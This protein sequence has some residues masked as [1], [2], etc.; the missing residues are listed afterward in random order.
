M[1]KIVALILAA[2]LVLSFAGCSGEQ[3]KTETSSPIALKAGDVELT[4]EDMNYMY[5][6]TF[7]DIYNTFYNYYGEYL[8]YIL[9]I[10]KPLEEQMLD[11]NLSWHQYVL[12]V[13]LDSTK[14]IIG[15]YKA[16][17]EN[18]F[19]LPE[20]YQNDIDTFDEQLTAI[21]EEYGMTKEEYLYYSYGEDV[22]AESVKNMTEIQLYCNA[23][24]ENYSANLEISDEDIETYY[25]ANK[26]A[27]DT[28]DFHFYTTYYGEEEALTQEEA[29]A[30]ANAIA[31][32]TTVE[33][34][35]ALAKDFT[36]DEADKQYF[37]ESDPT[38]YA[39][40]GYDA[41]G[42]EE[43]SEWLFDESRVT[44][45]TM[46]YH[47]EDYTGYIAIMFETRV[48]PDYDYIN[49]R[50][51]LIAPEKNAEGTVGDA[52]WAAAEAKANEIY[53]G[54][55]AG[56][57][58]EETF[59][60]LAKEYSADGNAAQGG[61]YENVYKG[62]MVPAFNDWCFD[63]A[64]TVGDSGIVKTPYGYHLMYFAGFGENNLTATVEPLVE[65][66][67]LSAFLAECEINSPAE[68]T[69]EINNVGGMLDD[70]VNSANEAAGTQDSET[71]KETKSFTGIIIGALVA[72]ILVC[73][74][75]IIKN[76][77]KKKS[78]TEVTEENEESE[79]AEESALEATEEDL[80]E[81][82]LAAEEAFEETASEETEEV[83]E[84]ESSEE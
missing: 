47:D 10:T 62:Q 12:D 3:S 63:E 76:G 16:A 66:E 59:S 56:E 14:T 11:E 81:E 51:I 53:N 58:T 44:G 70:I 20:D 78:E 84:E 19:V 64:R 83:T 9:D 49:I 54:Y 69:D 2:M 72:I 29:E 65:E 5:T 42:I 13:T 6:T 68:T 7:N 52:E 50:H 23:Y 22:S 61:I 40:A 60:E 75:I 17:K 33:E 34:F 43:I 48:D 32:A 73:I 57:M 39:G 24:I 45:D 38:L 15:V 67:R 4:V 31:E 35:V 55:L 79:E 18:G 27:I 71:E 74:I 36:T 82:E 8:A 28:V 30:Q 25:S 1:K 37:E 41:T 80:T 46:V 26:N 21:A 77:G